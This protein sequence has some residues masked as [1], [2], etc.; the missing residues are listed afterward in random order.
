FPTREELEDAVKVLE[1][2]CLASAMRLWKGEGSVQFCLPV[3][4]DGGS[5]THVKEAL[6]EICAGMELA[7]GNQ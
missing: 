5:T 4:E 1:S 7:A 3:F 2:T 6:I